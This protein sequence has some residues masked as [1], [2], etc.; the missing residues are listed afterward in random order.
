M[1]D[2]AFKK[3]IRSYLKKYVFKNVVTENFF[4]EVKRYS[5]FDTQK[6]SKVWLESSKF[7]TEEANELLLTNKTIQTQ[8]EIDKLKN[9]ALAEKTSFFEKTLQSAI[10]F[11]VKEALVYQLKTEKS[12]DK[13]PL[14]TLALDTKNTAVRQAVAQTTN[15]I[16]ENFRLQYETLLDD[17]S[18]QTQEI[19][20]FTLWNNFPE[21]RFFYLE[22]SKNWIG[23]ND[24]NLR[25][26]WLSLALSTPNYL[27]NK[28]L[29][30]EEL[31]RFSAPK[32][33]S[34]TRQEALE[35]LIGFGFLNDLV[36][37]NLVNATT[38]PVWQF[39]KFAR[40]NIRALVKKP[41]LRIS[42]E[43]ILPELNEAEHFQLQ[44]LLKE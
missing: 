20:L 26:L 22:K 1:G 28:A 7:N 30:I 34:A 5:Q 17:K 29:S 19:A 33:E 12:E 35:K 4:A 16:P 41:D 9:T 6:F 8:F 11:S 40:E 32:H 27:E 38:H 13:L 3:T 37:K 10:Y 25:I 18:Y 39:S 2:K 42:F 14:L 36:L 24:Y 23:F 21:R 43:R 44:R 31:V 15:P